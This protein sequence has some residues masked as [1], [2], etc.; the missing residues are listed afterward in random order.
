MNITNILL[1]VG[2][3][4]AFLIA[5]VFV[6]IRAVKKGA[7]RKKAVLTQVL[8]FVAVCIIS[9]AVPMSVSAA[10]GTAATAQAS[11]ST[12]QQATDNSKGMSMFAV[13]L[14][15][16]VASI[17]GAVAIATAAPA[18]IGAT[19]E[20]PEVFGKALV[21]VALGEGIAIFG[22]LLGIMMLQKI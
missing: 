12:S 8:S 22:L 11:T 7:N 2:I 13:A 5:S 4:V 14:A 1:C 20:N 16:A 21:F 6:A 3:P 15:D 10:D 9:M 19:G 17:G 18:A